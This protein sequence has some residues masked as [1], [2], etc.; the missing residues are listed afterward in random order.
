MS[1]PNISIHLCPGGLPRAAPP[2]LGTP[3]A[4][5][6]AMPPLGA[7]CFRFYCCIPLHLDIVGRRAPV[8]NTSVATFGGRCPAC[9]WSMLGGGAGASASPRCSLVRPVLWRL[10]PGTGLC[11]A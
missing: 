10:D 3:H 6:A 7:P 5:L 2:L 4:I 1:L 9:H 8:G 11:S